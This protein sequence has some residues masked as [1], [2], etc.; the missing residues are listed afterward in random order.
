MGTVKPRKNYLVSGKRDSAVPFV[1]QEEKILRF[2]LDLTL[3]DGADT[4]FP[5]RR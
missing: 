5:K 4:F 2:F 1:V 3:E